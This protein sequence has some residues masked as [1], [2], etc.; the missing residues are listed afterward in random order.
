MSKS[1]NLRLVRWA[2]S[3]YFVAGQIETQLDFSRTYIEPFAGSAIVFFRNSPKKAYL[4]DINPHLID[5][6]RDVSRNPIGVWREYSKIDISSDSYYEKRKYFNGSTH[7]LK[8]SATFLYLNHFCF[9]GIYRTNSKGEF[10][11]PYGGE[12]TRNKMSK[13]DFIDI[14]GRI[15]NV[16]FYK[17]DFEQFLIK[18]NPKDS[19][20]YVDP[21][22]FT[23][24]SRV[25]RE[26][27]SQTFSIR[28]LDR[29]TD[30]C[31]SLKKRGNRVVVSYKDCGE[32]WERFAGSEIRRIDVV[33]N[34][35]G[36]KSR[37][38]IQTEIL[39][40]L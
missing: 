30:I 21:P 14:S 37:R 17:L 34:V 11:T 39:A 31:Y 19:N 16:D 29:L 5:L 20:I 4:N 13:S 25:F 1:K 23:N 40:I 18:I 12:K 2:G 33:R 22:Y 6:Y 9:N 3:K 38:A 27:S 7:S 26:Y 10:N 28:D 8:R 36:F 32:F 15:S 24:E 35:G